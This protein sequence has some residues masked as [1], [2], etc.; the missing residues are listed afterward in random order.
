MSELRIGGE[1][2]NAKIAV[3]SDLINRHYSSSLFVRKRGI[4]GIH[5]CSKPAQVTI[6]QI[7]L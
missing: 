2:K 6:V 4:P 3:L 7:G 5:R 1:K